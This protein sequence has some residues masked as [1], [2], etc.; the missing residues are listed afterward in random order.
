MK[1]AVIILGLLAA[2]YADAQHHL[3][4]F[5]LKRSL[6][7]DGLHLQFMVLDTDKKGVRN[8]QPNKFYYWTKSQHVR[9]TQGAS[10][11]QLLHG[12]YEAFYPDKQLAEKGNYHKGL[13]HR[14]W[15]Y[16]HEDGTFLRKE[17]WRH[18]ILSGKQKYFDE[19]G[20]LVRT[21]HIQNGLKKKV[22]QSD[23][24]VHWKY[25]H[26]KTITLFDSTGQ[27][28]E[29]QHFKKNEL[30]GVQKTFINGKLENKHRYRTGEL[31]DKKEEESKDTEEKEPS[32]LAQFWNK[33]FKKGKGEKAEKDPKKKKEAKRK[34]KDGNAAEE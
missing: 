30:H 21:E 20:S 25:F 6:K 10:S 15:N 31:I 29:V 33:L 27:K 2:S 24:V 7:Q 5:S 17:N 8:H 22:V 18:G 19:N 9:A 3:E 23:S 34:R 14:S 13:K 11:G 28:K 32:N 4:D 12:L 16:W 1:Y 26:R